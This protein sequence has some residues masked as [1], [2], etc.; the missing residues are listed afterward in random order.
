[1]AGDGK[2]IRGREHPAVRDRELGKIYEE[3]ISPMLSKDQEGRKRTQ[4]IK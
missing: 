1:M 4:Q 3:K 2:R